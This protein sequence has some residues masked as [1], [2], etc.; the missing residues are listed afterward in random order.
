MGA[1]YHKYPIHQTQIARKNISRDRLQRSSTNTRERWRDALLWPTSVGHSPTL[2]DGS[3]SKK[4]QLM[5]GNGCRSEKGVG[6]AG[7]LKMGRGLKG[8]DLGEMKG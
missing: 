1:L 4:T 6:Q 7:L 3:H 8:W 2:T 5:V